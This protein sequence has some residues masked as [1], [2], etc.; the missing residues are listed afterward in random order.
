MTVGEIQPSD[1]FNSNLDGG[2]I[3]WRG[4]DLDTTWHKL[5]NPEGYR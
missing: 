2:Q 1:P 4:A 3:I 5:P